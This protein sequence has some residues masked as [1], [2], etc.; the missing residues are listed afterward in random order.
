MNEIEL[1]KAA[2]KGDLDSF[3]RLVLSY[4]NALYSQAYRLMG[5]HDAAEDATQD[6]FISAYKHLRSFRGGS[7]KAWLLRIVTNA[8]YDELRR[9]KRRPTIPLEPINL[10]NE[11]EV[12]NSVWMINPNETPEERTQRRELNTAIQHCLDILPIE[13]RS[14]AILVDVQGVDYQEAAQVIG[15]PIGTVKSRLCRARLR[16]KECLQGFWELLP[17]KYRLINEA[18]R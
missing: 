1:I 5:N 8:C 6:A 10:I 16:L 7:F 3:N 4:Q 11:E 14:V 2:Q 18:I 13:F 17:A 9:K 12:E 15:K